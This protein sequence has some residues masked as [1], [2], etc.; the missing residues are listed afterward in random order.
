ML[1]EAKK[2]LSSVILTTEELAKELSIPC[3]VVSNPELR[4]G[5]KTTYQKS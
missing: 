2:T 1:N 5:L 3:L 4:A